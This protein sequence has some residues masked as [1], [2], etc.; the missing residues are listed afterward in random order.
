MRSGGELYRPSLEELDGELDRIKRAG[1]FRRWLRA[2]VIIVILAACAGGYM[3]REHFMVVRVSGSSMEPTLQTGDIALYDKK[4]DIS[5]GDVV[6]FERDGMLQIKRVIGVGGDKVRVAESGQVYVNGVAV[7]EEYV[8]SA[9][10][11]KS[12]IVYPATVPAGHVFVM[13][14]NRVTSV[15]S[16]NSGVGFIAESELAGRV[17]IVLWPAYR[18][19]FF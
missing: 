17:R 18:I 1:S 6:L 19:R 7:E 8:L 16:R 13:G 9:S 11:G 12:D 2:L 3:M 5:R 10:L 15:D 4:A 14:D